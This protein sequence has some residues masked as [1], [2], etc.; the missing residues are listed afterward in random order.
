MWQCSQTPRLGRSEGRSLTAQQARAFLDATKG[1]RLELTLSK[2]A[3]RDDASPKKLST[4]AQAYKQWYAENQKSA[5]S[6]RQKDLNL[7]VSRIEADKTIEVDHYVYALGADPKLPGGA[8]AILGEALTA[9]MEPVFDVD[10][11]FGDV[12]ADTTVAMCSPRRDLWLVGAAV[13]RSLGKRGD[14]KLAIGDNFKSVAQM[15]C[16]AGTPPEGIAAVLASL[17]AVTG[18]YEDTAINLQTA[19][20]QELERWAG[21]LYQSRTKRPAPQRTVRM[22]ADQVVALRKHTV[23]GLTKEEVDRLSDPA[24]AFWDE[25]FATDSKGQYLI[26]QLAEA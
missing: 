3:A 21:K 8:Q 25:M 23:F 16:E 20:F 13:F 22:I 10:K 26:D 2:G 17:K 6:N 9:E 15:M 1:E 14:D 24:N 11:R 12:A 19:D 7:N 5:A 18:F 4:L